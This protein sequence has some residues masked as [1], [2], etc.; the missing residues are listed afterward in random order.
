MN[1]NKCDYVFAF[2][3]AMCIKEGTRKGHFFKVGNVYP[4]LGDNNGVQIGYET[5]SGDA[6]ILLCNSFEGGTLAPVDSK[7][8]PLFEVAT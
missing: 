6:S 4:I 5:A 7:E 3:M 8:A 2:H 1:V